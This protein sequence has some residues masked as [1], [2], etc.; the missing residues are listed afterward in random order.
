MP[1]TINRASARLANFRRHGPMHA[2]ETA[3]VV[4][5]VAAAATRDEPVPLT[6]ALS[7][8]IE[9]WQPIAQAEM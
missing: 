6:I 9:D 2:I 4:L 1:W 8:P 3:A 7:D 5:F